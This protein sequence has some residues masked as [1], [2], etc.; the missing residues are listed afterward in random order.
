MEAILKQ[1]NIKEPSFM[2]Q[3]KS[4]KIANKAKRYKIT[5]AASMAV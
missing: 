1:L 2:K 4:S 3:L 5:V